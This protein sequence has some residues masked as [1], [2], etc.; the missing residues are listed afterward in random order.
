MDMLSK[1]NSMILRGLGITS[2]ML[3]NLLTIPQFGLSRCNEMSFSTEKT[4]AFLNSLG[5]G[6]MIAEFIAFL[7]WAGVPVFVFLTGYGVAISAPHNSCISHYNP[8]CYAK[9]QWKKLF[10]LLIPMLIVFGVQDFLQHD[11]ATLLKRLLYPTFLVNFAYPYLRAVPGTYW[12][13]SLTF[14]YYLIWAFWG[15]YLMK[16]KILFIGSI[17]SLVGLWLFCMIDIPEVLSIYRHCFTGF[18]FIFALGVY[19]AKYED[20]WLNTVS[21]VWW[22]EVLL[23][24]LL[25]FIIVILHLSLESWLFVPLVALGFLFVVARLVIRVGFLANIFRWIGSLSACIFVC[26]PLIKS[27]VSKFGYRYT[28]NMLLFVLSYVILTLL[29]S[30]LYSQLYSYLRTKFV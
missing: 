13:F 4:W 10:L 28:D 19:L 27:V 3:H 2:I 17:L 11:Y 18:F 6:N 15:E 22:V 14:Q 8:V 25:L 12:Y 9:K 20:N 29:L 7:G 5:H 24:F 21:T 16:R 30:I 23:A 26:H 1:E